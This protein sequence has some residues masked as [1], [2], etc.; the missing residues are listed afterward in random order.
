MKKNIYMAG[1]L[2]AIL[3]TLCTPERSPIDYGLDKCHYCKMAIVD[4]RF[5]CELVTSKGKVYKFDATECLVHF[6]D[7]RAVPI[8]EVAML[9]T[10]TFDK[11]GE[12]VH[13]DHCYFLQSENMPSPMGKYINP[14]SEKNLAMEYK[15]SQSGSIY[16]WKELTDHVGKEYQFPEN[17]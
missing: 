12:L 5:G 10:N 13:V 2:L 15:E 11:P 14:F 6:M 3:C 17:R 16:Q 4:Q 9:L 8:D 7:T 1:T